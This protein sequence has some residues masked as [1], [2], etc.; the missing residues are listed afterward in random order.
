MLLMIW[1][2]LGRRGGRTVALGAAILVASLGFTVL[3]ASARTSQLRTIG[4]VQAHAR[5]VYDILV[6]PPGARS[7]A[8]VSQGLIA[9]GLL[10]A[11]A[12]GISLAQW[13]RIQHVPGV[14]VAAP[15]AVLGYVAPHVHLILD[16]P[17]SG[18]RHASTVRVDA[19]WSD[20]P[21]P[22][23]AAN[24][25]FWYVAAQAAG[26][27]GKPPAEDSTCGPPTAD[28]SSSAGT[29]VVTAPSTFNCS[30]SVADLTREDSTVHSGVAVVYPFPLLLVAVDPAAED[31]L[32]GL[33]TASS[34]GALTALTRSPKTG[35]SDIGTI[36]EVPVLMASKS[37]VGGSVTVGV[38]MLPDPANRAVAAG[39]PLSVLERMT[40]PVVTQHTFTA[41]AAYQQLRSAMSR[42]TPRW[43]APGFTTQYWTAGA[44]KLAVGSGGVLQASTVQNDIKRLW[45]DPSYFSV[46]PVGADD[47]QFRP[48]ALERDSVE[49]GHI[50][51]GPML[52]RVGDFESSKLTGL[53]DDTA[54]ILA[55]WDT[56]LTTGADAASRDALHDRPV[57]PST[58]MGALVAPPPL[59]VTSIADMD[60]ML[61]GNWHPTQRS[62]T[63]ITAVRVRV[64][65]VTG[66]DAASRAR[67]RLAAERIRQ[68]TGLVVDVTVGA[69]ATTKTLSEPAGKFGRPALLL[70][71]PWVKMGVATAIIAAVDKKSVVLFALILVVS[72]LTVANSVF[73]SVRERRTELGVLASLGWQRRHLFAIVAGEIATVAVCSGV[74]AGIVGMAVG[75]P[76]GTQIGV[77]RAALAVPVAALVALTAGVLP[78]WSA[79]RSEPMAA[80][81]PVVSRPRKASRVRSVGGMGR[82]NVTRNLGRTLVAAL[83]LL[84]GVAGFT[85]LLAITL[86]FQGAFVGTVL[87]DAIIVQARGVD[88]AAVT[89]ILV[90]AGLG[91]AN[92]LYLSIRDRGP[93]LATLHAIGWE[94]R[95]LDRMLLTEGMAIAALGALPGATLGILGALALTGSLSP[96]SLAA[97]GIGIL[98]AL[99]VTMAASVLSTGF[100]HRLPITVLL[101]E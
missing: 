6:R 37:P 80:I 77:G 98:V 79:A 73:A 41:Q 64:S 54:R 48:L 29:T 81:Q 91:V 99:L 89:A 78:A 34:P 65:G 94:R 5:T 76:L 86:G 13:R 23:R 35:E 57:S 43:S 32:D 61:A 53:A 88:Y 21:S 24:P 90:L 9:P 45:V 17:Q 74:L 2:Q 1:T 93:E 84:I 8:E 49:G 95:H 31:T 10:S 58:A 82:T 101:T 11:S 47:T 7:T 44:P 71:Q 83:G 56:V 40:G 75:R 50:S 46:A 55:G 92:V 27:P 69:S 22:P 85:V 72:A 70:H 62:A 15:I 63:P 52:T 30:F 19:E 66:V 38:R 96:A 3:T 87:G 28:A 18:L 26:A 97:G 60:P 4:S 16:T 100:V 59:M 67:V 12:G 68:A 39:R 25:Q 14:E 42:F 20:P 33:G 51:G 36:T